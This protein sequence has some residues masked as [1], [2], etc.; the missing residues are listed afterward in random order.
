LHD[1]VSR[2]PNPRLRHC[3]VLR[4][5]I[6]TAVENCCWFPE[7]FGTYRVPLALQLSTIGSLKHHSACMTVVNGTSIAWRC[8]A[9]LMCD[10]RLSAV[11]L[12]AMVKRT[13]SSDGL[14][15]T[16]GY[17]GYRQPTISSWEMHWWWL[18]ARPITLVCPWRTRVALPYGRRYTAIVTDRVTKDSHAVR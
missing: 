13:G 3:C 17:P 11:T 9:P 2:I 14:L 8:C 4:F 6:L 18:I 10:R 15:L 12:I 1:E 7:W 5:I 16:W